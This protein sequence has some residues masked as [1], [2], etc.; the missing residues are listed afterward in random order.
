MNQQSVIISLLYKY[1][2]LAFKPLV[3][4]LSMWQ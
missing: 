4:V 2:T 1:L 3:I